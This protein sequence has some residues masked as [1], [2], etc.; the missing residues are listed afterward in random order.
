MTRSERERAER[1]I[2]G[3]SEED[4]IKALEILLQEPLEKG[5]RDDLSRWLIHLT[6]PKTPELESAA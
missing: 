6:D 2:S 5:L 3:P 1:D 4:Q